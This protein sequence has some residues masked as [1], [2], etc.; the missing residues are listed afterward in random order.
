MSGLEAELHKQFAMELPV[1]QWLDSD[2]RLEEEGLRARIQT[3][4]SENYQAK[5]EVVGAETIRGF[6]K[7]VMLQVIDSRWKEHLATMDMLR[8]GIHLRGYAQKSQARI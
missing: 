1:Q 3:T 4:L 6:E 5:T 8:Q 7:Q 2:D